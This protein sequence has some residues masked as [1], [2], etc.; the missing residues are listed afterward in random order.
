MNSLATQAFSPDS[1]RHAWTEIQ[2]KDASDGVIGPAVARFAK[3]DEDQLARLV[4]EL[5]WGGYSPGVLTEVQ[6]PS[7]EDQRTLHVPSVRDRIVARSM[8]RSVTPLIDPHLGPASFAYRPGLGVVDASQALAR[9][10]EEGLGYV[11]RTDIDQC[12]PNIPVPHARR[13]M[14]ALVDDAEFLAI[15]DLLLARP[16]ASPRRGIRRMRGLPQGCPL[17]PMLAN[18]VL[19]EVDG[20]LRAEGFP[21]VRYADDIAVA[22]SSP[23]DAWEAARMLTAALRR[24][25]M[26]LGA[27]D[28]EVMSFDEGFTFLGEDFGPRYPP[29][30][31][32]AR[33]EEPDR[34]VLY[35]ATQGG[36]VRTAGG[37]LIIENADEAEILDVPNGLVSRIVCFGSVGLSAG[38]RSWA[39]ANGVSVIFASRRGSYQ[40][41]FVGNH[42][43]RAHRVRQQI[44]MCGS[45]AA[46]RLGRAIV[47]AKVSKQIVVLQRFSRREHAKEVRDAIVSMS[48][49]LRLLPEAGSSAEIMGVEGAAA[50]AYFPALGALLPPDL[51]FTHRTRQPPLDVANAALS[52][53]YTLLLGECVTALYAAG[54][55]P[56]FGVLHVDD[57]DRPSLALDLI[58]EFRP[59]VV[60]Q[61][62]VAACRK[63]TL[64]S[65]D[66]R[67]EEGRAGVL[68]SRGGRDALL[69]AYERR[70]LTKTSG[71][72][73]DFGGT[74]RRH[75]YRQAQRLAAAIAAE[76]AEWTGMSWR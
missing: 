13:L 53:L 65:T 67:T 54:L 10:R 26:E 57:D 49:M 44:G 7:G 12:F 31:E 21:I 61:I 5:A 35:V 6:I 76:D 16:F 51:A 42:R 28:T 29:V 3:D 33:V 72:L 11:L 22:T 36:R 74:L 15:L 40:G 50:A 71:A 14:G 60:D 32:D 20:D 43:S 45:P 63:G 25:D 18:L 17:S 55:D 52:F 69:A 24:L 75:L 58:E 27:D 46:L 9:L 73:P 64:T 68:L 37:R 59:L 8:L 19:A 38:V 62:V 39:F 56:V 4:A 2:A 34:R 1:L 66:V 23:G 48:N 41:S 30:L 47:Q 70:M